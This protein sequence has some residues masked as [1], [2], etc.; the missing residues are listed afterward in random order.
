MAALGV[1]F[2]HTN[3][4]NYDGKILPYRGGAGPTNVR[5]KGSASLQARANSANPPSTFIRDPGGSGKAIKFFYPLDLRGI[6][7]KM[8]GHPFNQVMDQQG[9]SFRPAGMIFSA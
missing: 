3:V 1:G 6:E 2:P 5:P 7:D 9:D 8:K 4:R